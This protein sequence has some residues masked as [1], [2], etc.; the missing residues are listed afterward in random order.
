M[1]WSS[2]G[3]HF[4]PVAEAL[5]KLGA[6]DEV[7]TGVC[8][9]LIESLQGGDWD[10]EGESLGEFQD[11]PAIVAAFREQGVFLEYCDERRPGVPWRY[12]R[13]E[14]GHKGAHEDNQGTWPNKE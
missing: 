9:A 3:Y 13:D 1:G 7:K 6:S 5:I 8:S 11:D 12:C 2:G 14:A 10:T 4:G